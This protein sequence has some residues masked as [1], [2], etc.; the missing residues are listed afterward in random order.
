MA[1]NFVWF[2]EGLRQAKGGKDPVALN[3]HKG[4]LLRRVHRCFTRQWLGRTIAMI[5]TGAALSR[6]SRTCHFGGGPG[7]HLPT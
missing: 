4:V 6:K 2:V 5:E 7:R 1:L 3:G